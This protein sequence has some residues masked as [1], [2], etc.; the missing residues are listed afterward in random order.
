MHHSKDYQPDVCMT[1]KCLDRY[2]WS[3]PANCLVDDPQSRSAYCRPDGIVSDNDEEINRSGVIDSFQE[4]VLF[5]KVSRFDDLGNIG[6]P[7][8][9]EQ[10]AKSHDT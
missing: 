8:K 7:S 10:N 5:D 2:P 9:I 1:T 6:I 4:P 3:L